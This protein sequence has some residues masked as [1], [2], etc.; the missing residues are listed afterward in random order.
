MLFDEKARRIASMNARNNSKLLNE[1]IFGAKWS[2]EMKPK[3][4]AV[5]ANMLI[6]CADIDVERSIMQPDGSFKYVIIFSHTY[7]YIYLQNHNSK[8]ASIYAFY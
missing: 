3:I 2:E 5:L 4:G 6:K 7:T 8:G 1:R